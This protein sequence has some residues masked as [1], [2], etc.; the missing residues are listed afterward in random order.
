MGRPILRKIDPALDI[1]RHFCELDSL[2]RPWNAASVFGRSGPLEVEV[3]TGKGM[4]LRKA[5]AGTPDVDFLGIEIALK[6]A[7]YA[8][9]GLAKAE[10]TNAAVIHGD[11]LRFFAEWLP[12]LSVDA[13]HIYFPDPWWKKRHRKR[14]VM[15]ESLVRDIFRV[16]IPGGRL[17]FWTDVADYFHESLAIIAACASL[18]GPLPVPEKPAENDMDFRT[19]FERRV[20]LEGGTI[21]RCEF[22]K[23]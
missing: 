16:L 2:P 20:R 18:E 9:A 12:D 3:G 14:R 6:Y 17:H 1:S 4:F 8:A 21:Y 23:P 7:K 5:A 10:L 22:R 11:A 19:H 15:R 13:V